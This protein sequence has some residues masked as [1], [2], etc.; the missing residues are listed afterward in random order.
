MNIN[1]INGLNGVGSVS[2]TSSIKRNNGVNTETKAVNRDEMEIKAQ[3]AA[4][5]TEASMDMSD[6]RLSLVERVRAEIAAG[7]YYSDEKFE[8]AVMRMFDSFDN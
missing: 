4:R 2:Q 7:T 3:S 6:V 5:T 1:G 8:I